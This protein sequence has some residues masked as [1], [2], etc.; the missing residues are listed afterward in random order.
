MPSPP[1]RSRGW[2]DVAY[3]QGDL[4]A[5]AALYEESLLHPAPRSTTGRAPPGRWMAS[6]ASRGIAVSTAAPPS[7]SPNAWPCAGSMATALGCLSCLRGLADV[8]LSSGRYERAARFLSATARLGELFGSV[9][10]DD[11]SQRFAAGHWPRP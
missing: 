8:A 3:R 1:L 7:C 5:A 2:A 10:S 4:D 11:A 6:G 9:L